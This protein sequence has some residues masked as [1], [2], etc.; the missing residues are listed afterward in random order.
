MEKLG[1]TING[2]DLNRSAE[3]YRFVLAVLTKISNGEA[4][5][6]SIPYNHID[7]VMTYQKLARSALAKLSAI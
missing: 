2:E 5:N 7:T 4:M 3:N 1:L 6:P